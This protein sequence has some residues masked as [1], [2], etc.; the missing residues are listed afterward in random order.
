[1]F[2]AFII[3]HDPSNIKRICVCLLTHRCAMAQSDGAWAARWDT[4]LRV[5]LRC[6]REQQGFFLGR[7]VYTMMQNVDHRSGQLTMEMQ[8]RVYAE[9]L[10]ILA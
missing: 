6:V 2:L 4:L 9:L 8:I 1:M 3:C 5:R 10:A 7:V